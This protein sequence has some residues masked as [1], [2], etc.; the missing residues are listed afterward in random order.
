MALGSGPSP[1]GRRVLPR[2]R[3]EWPSLLRK[4]CERC[5]R[6]GASFKI[7]WEIDGAGNVI[8][9]VIITLTHQLL[10]GHVPGA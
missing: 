2:F 5:S 7:Q 9:R 4:H 10:N 6:R 8:N 1:G 3:V